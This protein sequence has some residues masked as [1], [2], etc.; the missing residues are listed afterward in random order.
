[1]MH[2]IWAKPELPRHEQSLTGIIP[3]ASG[4]SSRQSQQQHPDDEFL[5]LAMI[6]R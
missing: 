5:A 1:M 4:P 6:I 3:D 2:A